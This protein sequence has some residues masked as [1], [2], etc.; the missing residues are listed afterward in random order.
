L[1]LLFTL[2]LLISSYTLLSQYKVTIIAT[3][4]DKNISSI[5]LAGDI[6]NW[7][8]N[9][10]SFIFQKNNASN[11]NI[12]I[13]NCPKKLLFKCTKGNWA[14]VECKPDGTDIENRQFEILSD[15]IIRIFIEGF[16]DEFEKIENKITSSA[17]T[18][19]HII[20]DSFYIPQLKLKRR[21]W[22][23]LPKTYDGKKKFAVLYMH[24]GQ[25]LF[26]KATSGY[27][28]WGI[29]EYLDTTQKQCII[30]GIDN[31]KNRMTEYNPYNHN[32]FGI[33]QGKDYLK[34]IVKS[35]KPFVDKHYKTIATKEHTFIAG[36]SMGGLISYYAAVQFPK[37]FGKIGIFSPAFWINKNDLLNTVR[38]KSS[39]RNI[40]FYF[41]AGGNEST[42]MVQDALGIHY[43]TKDKCI[44]CT[45]HLSIKAL[46]EHNEK[47]WQKELPEFFTWLLK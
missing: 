17:S 28:E 37:T 33:G 46:G 34:F 24:D 2:L 8:P 30:V 4:K 45:I 6:N 43:L 3:T 9:N 20:S 29:D 5:Y 19:V 44:N 27:G 16:K 18:Q 7:Q 13:N 1:K 11:F 39:F 23:Y 14:N 41:Y 38:K 40:D 35:L 12:T 10:N 21:I 36:S 31:G 42:T 32:K 47:S 22:I 26:D 15:T 25:N